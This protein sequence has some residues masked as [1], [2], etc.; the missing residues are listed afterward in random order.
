MKFILEG[1]KS[2]L[3]QQ[4]SVKAPCTD[5][6]V[7]SSVTNGDKSDNLGNA[8]YGVRCVPANRT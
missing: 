8:T 7:A 2:K 6:D 5:A 1:N 4:H 3:R